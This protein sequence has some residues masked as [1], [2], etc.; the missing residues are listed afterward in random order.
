MI[1][2]LYPYNNGHLM[3]V[4]YAHVDSLRRARRGHSRS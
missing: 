1:M 4:P 2:N 3:M